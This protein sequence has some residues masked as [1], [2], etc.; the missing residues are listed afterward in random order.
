VS[1]DFHHL[2]MPPY[3]PLAWFEEAACTSADPDAWHPDRGGSVADA[4]RVC[5]RCPV[6]ADCLKYALDTDQWQGI[7]GG[8]SPRQRRALVRQKD[9]A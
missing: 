2:T 6:I 4:K 1:Q 5:R 8:L 7:W 9:A 3:K